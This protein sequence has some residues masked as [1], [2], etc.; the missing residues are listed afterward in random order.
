MTQPGGDRVSHP[1]IIG[2]M[3]PHAIEPR[4]RDAIEREL[5]NISIKFGR[6]FLT[7]ARV[8]SALAKARRSA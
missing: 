4:E 7:I 8:A 5:E 2:A 6:S 3:R 1:D